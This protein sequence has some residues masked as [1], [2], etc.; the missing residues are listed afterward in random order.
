M[1]ALTGV[2][3]P[4]SAKSGKT[5]PGCRRGTRP[6][7]E[8]KSSPASG[9]ASGSCGDTICFVQTSGS[10]HQASRSLNYKDPASPMFSK[11]TKTGNVLSAI[12]SQGFRK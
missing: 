12:E 5:S 6:K 2:V 7:A 8:A 1:R 4:K 9:G 10:A 11:S 3:C